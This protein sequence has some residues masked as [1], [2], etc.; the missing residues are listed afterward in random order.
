MKSQQGSCFLSQHLQSGLQYISVGLNELFKSNESAI[1]VVDSYVLSIFP[2]VAVDS[3]AGL[4][5]LSGF[6]FYALTPVCHFGG[7]KITD[8]R[9]ISDNVAHCNVPVSDAGMSNICFRTHEARCFPFLI[10]S[11]TNILMISPLQIAAH[12]WPVRSSARRSLSKTPP[13]HL[14]NFF[15]FPADSGRKGAVG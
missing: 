10:V 6:N 5:T 14:R 11:T 4:V 7:M 3:G 9:I 13:C 1:M 8:A 2:S 12:Q 15:A